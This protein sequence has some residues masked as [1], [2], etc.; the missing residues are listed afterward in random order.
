VVPGSLKNTAIRCGH[1]IKKFINTMIRV[2]PLCWAQVRSLRSALSLT[3]VSSDSVG[4]M[5]TPCSRR[6]RIRSGIN[7]KSDKDRT[8]WFT[9]GGV[10]RLNP[11]RPRDREGRS[12]N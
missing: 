8:I 6:S 10:Y 12:G 11:A 5:S 3:T 9:S 1:N 7:L 2:Y 4:N